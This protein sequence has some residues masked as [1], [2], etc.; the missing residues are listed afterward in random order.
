MK[1]IHYLA[2]ILWGLA[3]HAQM[4]PITEG[5][6]IQHKYYTLSYQEAYEQ[7]SWVM[8]TLKPEMVKFKQAKRKNDF[9]PDYLV[10][11]G[12]A[13]LSDYYKSG[14]DRGHLCPA[15]DMSFDSIAM[16]ETF[17]MSNMSPQLPGFNRYIW[18]YAEEQVRKWVVEC[19]SIL[20]I[21]GPL[22]YSDSIK[23]IGANK[24]GIADYFYK[25]LLF[26]K[27]NRMQTAAFL[28]PHEEGLKG[29]LNYLISVDSL[30]H[31]SGYDFFSNLDDDIEDVIE[32]EVFRGW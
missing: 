31:F 15:G 14:Y 26:Y 12:S 27:G 24:V 28:I 9:R 30:E 29:H 6:I 20:V 23:T 3:L 21:T 32:K 19:D 22:F 16:S 7:P 1:I 10:S 18:R 5:E 17:F 25:A 13:Q 8:Y 11:T 4:H 2:V